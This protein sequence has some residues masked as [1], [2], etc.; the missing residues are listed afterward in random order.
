[1][2]CRSKVFRLGLALALVATFMLALVPAESEAQTLKTNEAGDTYGSIVTQTEVPDLIA[3]VAT[4][5]QNGFVKEADFFG[6]LPKNPEEAIQLQKEQ[7]D[8]IIPVYKNDGITVI[9]EFVISA[10]DTNE[11]GIQARSLYSATSSKK[12]WTVGSRTYYGEATINLS[13]AGTKYASSSV[14][15]GVESG[16]SVA[17]GNLGI[18]PYVVN[19]AGTIV[20]SKDTSFNSSDGCKK[21]TTSATYSTSSG[22]YRAYGHIFIWNGTSYKGDT[23]YNSPYLNF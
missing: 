23:T 21:Y 15:L 20:A 19:A 17:A 16:T 7:K 6:E 11:S 18:R 9:G 5:G 2:T 3:A 10:P 1:M 13:K 8:R 14:S 4:N 22:T 12:F